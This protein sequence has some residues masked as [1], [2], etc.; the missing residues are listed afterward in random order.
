[1]FSKLISYAY[2]PWEGATFSRQL[3]TLITSSPGLYKYYFWDTHIMYSLYI[4]TVYPVIHNCIS[5][6]TST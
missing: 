5:W 4:P 6:V 3:T 1:M 2:L